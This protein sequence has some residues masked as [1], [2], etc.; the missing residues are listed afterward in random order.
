MSAPK[1][2]AVPSSTTALV[3]CGLAFGAAMIPH[4]MIKEVNPDDVNGCATGAMNFLAFSF[5]AFVDWWQ[6]IR[7]A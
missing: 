1:G 5:S 4:T 7:R 2:A 3:G 6:A